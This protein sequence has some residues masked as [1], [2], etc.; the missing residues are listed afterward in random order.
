[1]QRVEP[2]AGRAG[3]RALPHVGELVR[4][5]DGA[6]R[7]V[8][9][10]RQVHRAIRPERRQPGWRTLVDDVGRLQALRA[11]GLSGGV[12]DWGDHPHRVRHGLHPTGC[13]Q[14]LPLLRG[15]LSVRRH[16]HERAGRCRKVHLLLRPAAGGPHPSLRAG[17][18]DGFDSVR[19]RQRAAA[20]RR[21]TTPAAAA[22]RPHPGA[23]VRTRRRDA[24]RSQFEDTPATYGL[25][26]APHLPSR[27]LP[28]S[29]GLGVV[30]AV[31][32]G[33]A[34][35]LAMRKRRIDSV[36]SSEEAR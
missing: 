2:A 4:Q 10:P 34:G 23:P 20:A 9:S 35:V 15:R 5:H 17:V 26:E 31:L 22:G 32:A 19:T 6:I 11:G 14:R 36:E 29:G 18:S 12:P 25:P 8:I 24:R 3:C 33:I 28:T 30:A 13:V 16:Q 1:V 27:N 7:N 21:Y